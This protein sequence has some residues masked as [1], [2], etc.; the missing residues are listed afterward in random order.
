MS[1]FGA[2]DPTLPDIEEFAKRVKEAD[3]RRQQEQDVLRQQQ[4]PDRQEVP[5]SPEPEQIR[6][7]QTVNPQPESQQQTPPQPQ[8]Q[9]QQSVDQSVF[10]DLLNA[11]HLIHDEAVQIKETLQRLVQ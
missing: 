5:P 7:S 3:A 1:S 2:Q 11:L 9:S 4:I 10:R 6:V 8:S